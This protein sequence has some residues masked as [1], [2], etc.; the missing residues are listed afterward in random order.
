VSIVSG[1]VVVAEEGE[2]VEGAVG[3]ALATAAG[4]HMA[5]CLSNEEDWHSRGIYCS[6]VA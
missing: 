1:E 5:R 2:E 4:S 3:I 6:G